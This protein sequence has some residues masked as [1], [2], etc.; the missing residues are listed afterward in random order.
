M[1]SS[2][3]PRHSASLDIE[4]FPSDMSL[5][6]ILLG[7]TVL[8]QD[9]FFALWMATVEAPVTGPCTGEFLNCPRDLGAMVSGT[10]NHLLMLLTPGIVFGLHTSR[11]RRRRSTP[12]AETPF[13]GAVDAVEG[14]VREARLSREPVVMVDRRLTSGAY[15]TG[16]RRR[17]LL[18]LG[19]EL[20]V[21]R[22]KGD[23]GRRIFEAVV[24]HELA[25]LRGRD[26]QT[27]NMVTVFRPSNLFAGA[28]I[29]FA[30]TLSMLNHYST[31]GD[32]VV[33]LVRV[34]L[35]T[36][37]GELIV[38]AYLRIREHHADLHAGMTDR[39]GLLAALGA[40]N[41]RADGTGA[42]RLRS[43][44]RHHPMGIDRL[45]V[46]RTPGR[47][48]ASSPGRVFLGATVAGVLLPMLQDLLLRVYGQKNFTVVLCGFVVGV[49]L[50]LFVGFTL[51]RHQWYAG[52]PAP[53]RL[54]RLALTGLIVAGGIVA[55]SRLALY[56]RVAGFGLSGTPL[57]PSFLAA[58][59]G[60][61]VLLCGW[62]TVVGAQWFRGD[63]QAQ[64]I[65]RFLK[66]AV[67]PA[68]LIGG[69]LLAG[70]WTWG[71]GLQ[72]VLA[73]CSTEG[74]VCPTTTPELAVANAVTGSFGTGPVAMTVALIVL[75]APLAARFTAPLTGRPSRAA[76][77]PRRTP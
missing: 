21:L 71:M 40:E 8:A 76:R 55:G 26:L 22:E 16:Q 36:L 27:Y 38:R 14:L 11:R 3:S 29:A 62:L 33:A 70:V 64:R 50:T 60:A 15:V 69:W 74:Y 39:E 5:M 75:A 53:A 66:L 58:L 46:A 73:A 28:F 47:V 7:V 52:G 59:A 10:F 9:L 24:R 72:S 19:P 18:M 30:V 34:L 57:A 51:W 77:P 12:L 65:P 35:L 13:H 42:A 67:V 31:P 20:L 4:A 56:T 61:A 44:L 54:G 17:P 2:A 48:L 1:N 63:P 68:C 25:H 45:D 49:G 32:L 41:G 23:H 37:L 43:W 6:L